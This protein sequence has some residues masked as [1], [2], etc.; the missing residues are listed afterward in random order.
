[1]HL[2]RDRCGALVLGPAVRRAQVRSDPAEITDPRT[3]ILA[4]VRRELLRPQPAAIHALADDVARRYGGRVLAILFYGACLRGG[5]SDGLVDF[6]VIVERYPI[7]PMSRIGGLSARVL[8]PNVYR[9]EA[10]IEERTL[11]AKAA[12]ISIAQLRRRA[13]PQALDTT[14]WARFCQ[15]MALVYARD[16]A[17]AEMLISLVADA[18]VIA[19]LWAARLGPESGASREFWSAL[20][21]ATYEG[22]LRVE[23]N[24]RVTQIHDAAPERYAALLSEA[25]AV[26]GLTGSPGPQA[27]NPLSPSM[28]RIQRRAWQRRR[29]ARRGLNILRL[30]KAAFTYDGGADYIA[31]KIERHAGQRLALSAFQ[32]RHPLL[33]IPS[34]LRQA[35]QLRVLR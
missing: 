20:F 31:W 6:Y 11:R 1:M 17:A 12:V 29:W 23:G 7:N 5:T 34:I 13:V 16:A 30:I 27:A 26:L 25:W 35:I 32:R 9:H 18:V 4:C 24:D 10:N 14:I 19:G 28:R 2:T 33:A 8:P 21:R 22:E 15:P 3:R